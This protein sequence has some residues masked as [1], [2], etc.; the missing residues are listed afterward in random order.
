MWWGRG[1]DQA[2]VPAP[3]R[4]SPPLDFEQLSLHRHRICLYYKSHNMLRSM[5]LRLGPLSLESEWLRSRKRDGSAQGQI[6]RSWAELGSELWL[7]GSQVSKLQ[8]LRS[9]GSMRQRLCV[10][11]TLRLYPLTGL[12]CLAAIFPGKESL[13]ASGDRWKEVSER[14]FLHWWNEPI[15]SRL[16]YIKRQVY[17]EAALRWIHW[18]QG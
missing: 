7:L 15:Q 1:A 6:P 2:H 4:P 10:I 11:L 16:E 18:P 9:S 5:I 13:G 14:L 3:S 17:W 8:S 12:C